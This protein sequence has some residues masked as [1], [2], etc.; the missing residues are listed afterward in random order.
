MDIMAN[1]LLAAGAS[2]AM[3][4]ALDEV[5]DGRRLGGG[6]FPLCMLSAQL[7]RKRLRH[8][9]HPPPQQ[10]PPPS[11]VEDFVKISSALLINMGTL[12][13]DWIAA[14]KLAAKQA[15]T[16]GKPWV[17]D[18]VGCGATPYRTAAC[19]WMLR[20]GPAVVRGNASEIMALA[21]AAGEKGGGGCGFFLGGVYGCVW[22]CRMK[23]KRRRS[24]QQTVACSMSF[25]Q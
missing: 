6:L 24:E 25:K 22:C 13:A 12:S 5:R 20:L 7:Q 4:H 15:T 23:G 18:P 16:M 17:L 11:Q 14:K 2:P 1:V 10:K 3:A 21:G 19:L 8:H 9:E